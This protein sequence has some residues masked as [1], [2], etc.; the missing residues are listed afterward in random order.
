MRTLRFLVAGATAVTALLVVQGSSVAAEGVEITTPYPAVV[1]TAGD[2]VTFELTVT[3]A[4]K[5]RVDLA[6][7]Q[8]PDGWTTILRGGGF[9]ID[10]VITDPGNP[11]QVELNVKVPD[12]ATA[13]SSKVV[14]KATAANGSSD[15]LELDLRVSEG[16]G[17][18]ASFSTDFPLQQGTATDIFN[19]DLTLSNDTPKS[20]TFSLAALQSPPGWQVDVRPAGQQQAVTVTVD[21]GSTASVQVTVDPPDDATADSYQLTIVA[22]GGNQNVQLPLQVDITGNFALTLQTADQRLS[23]DLQ[24]GKAKDLELLLLNNGT[25]PLSGI[26]LSATPPQDWDV[27]FSP[28]TVDTIGP[29]ET[30]QVIATIVSASNVVA[31]DYNVSITASGSEANASIELRTTVKT[32]GLWGLFGIGLIIA[33]LA[34]LV[35]VFRRYGRR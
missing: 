29:G 32:S 28:E 31:G 24:A 16:A 30:A 12:D 13:G 35:Y 21:A 7:T 4:G 8:R 27:T 2:S 23:T 9:L 25:A 18:T 10:G 19:F 14:V 1:V 5:Q 26:T 11:P 20:I 3:A 22:A 6:V 34:G 17:G 33:A 15:S